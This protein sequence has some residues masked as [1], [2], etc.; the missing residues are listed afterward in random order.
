MSASSR[1]RLPGSDPWGVGN[2]K[3]GGPSTYRRIGDTCPSSCP[4]LVGACYGLKT[5]ARMASNRCQGGEAGI[6]AYRAAARYAWDRGLKLRLHTTGDFLTRGVLDRDYMR[7]ILADREAGFR[8]PT[9]TYTHVR[10]RDLDEILDWADQTGI[11]VLPSDRWT[12][13]GA[14][15]VPPGTEIQELRRRS[16]GLRLVT[17]PAQTHAVTCA[18]CDVCLHA[19]RCGSTVIFYQH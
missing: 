2:A 4:Y 5:H 1:Y 9:W 10:G 14:V 17:C 12:P 15:V 16:P 18:A 13:G 3:I 8:P 6:L 7:A 19:T 11:T